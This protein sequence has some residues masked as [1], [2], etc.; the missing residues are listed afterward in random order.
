MFSK[1]E[2]KY[3]TTLKY[4]NASPKRKKIKFLQLIRVIAAWI[5]N[6]KIAA[7]DAVGVS[8]AVPG[9][10]LDRMHAVLKSRGIQVK[11]THRATAVGIT[12]KQRGNIGP[13]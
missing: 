11:I 2:P 5:P 8:R 13:V 6:G 3:N 1:A 12:G 9:G 7:A 4:K 10:P